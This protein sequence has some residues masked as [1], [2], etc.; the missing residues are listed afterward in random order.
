MWEDLKRRMMARNTTHCCLIGD[1]NCLRSQHETQGIGESSYKVGEAVEFNEF[2]DDIELIDIPL[3]GRKFTW[4]RPN[5]SVRSH[6]DRVLVSNDW[7]YTWQGCS[8]YVIERTFSDHCP[9]LLKDTL[10]IGGPKLFK[11]C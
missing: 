9:L 11:V 5:E 2:I 6:I 8:Q 3:I 7:I 1:F 10:I 4:Y